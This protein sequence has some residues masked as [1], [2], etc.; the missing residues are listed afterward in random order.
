MDNSTQTSPSRDVEA[1]VE[2]AVEHH[3]AGRVEQAEPIYRQALA[4]DPTHWRASHNLGTILLRRGEAE[5]A[6]PWLAAAAASEPEG[7]SP[8]AWLAHAQA[9][10][11]AQRFEEAEAVVTAR[12][13]DP[14]AL[15]AEKRLR[16]AWGARLNREHKLPEAKAQLERALSLDPEDPDTNTDLGYLHL[17]MT[18]AAGAIPFLRKVLARTPDALAAV[19]NLASA[20]RVQGQ[21]E[22]AERLY[23][24]ALEIDPQSEAAVINLS[25]VLTAAGRTDEA[26]TLAE[27]A[28]A[29]G[30]TGL[31]H[32]IRADALS[33]SG[34]DEEAITAYNAALAA[35][36]DLVRARYRRAFSRLKLGDFRRGWE[37]YEYRW[38]NPNF[39]SES[40][41]VVLPQLI[42]HLETRLTGADLAGK[43]VL[44]VGEQGIGDQVM[45]ASCIP[46]L[47]R[48]ADRVV[49]VCV[50][51]LARLFRGSF[52]AN[53]EVLEPREAK[54]SLSDFDHVFAI[55]S[56][57]RLYRNEPE[58]FPSTPYLKPN[59]ARVAEWAERLGPKTK[60]LRVGVSWRG[61]T[62]T[63]RGQQRSL[64][65][66]NLEPVLG[67]SDCEFVNLQYGD[68][69]DEV[70][71]FNEGRLNPIR[72]FPKADMDDFDDLAALVSNLDVVV[73]VQTALVHLCGAIGQECLTMLPR[74]PEWR[75]APGGAAMYW[76]RSVRLLRQI[77]DGEW[78]PVINAIA[79]DL[80]ARVA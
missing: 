63:T 32:L 24:R 21:L 66:A 13:A 48:Q 11:A 68:V 71:A 14:R 34:R 41:A 20:L 51:R 77:N 49:L 52:P 58:D 69:A 62:K 6:L 70:E 60:R 45:F 26:L 65:L 4:V 7:T 55:G 33:H 76:Y 42:P 30:K 36:P 10:I 38:L 43:R 74:D 25:V 16:Q 53:V 56:L 73:S 5:A 29:Q 37:D 46:D 79:D 35:R 28:F 22:E 78:E 59:P 54:L 31:G 72:L 39:V 18:D 9:L 1:L 40:A 80:R 19:V 12:S 61:G 75:Y 23:R 15:M 47:A 2:A 17:Q 50:S 3:R 8:Q 44:V 67:L 64:T 57:G 27:H